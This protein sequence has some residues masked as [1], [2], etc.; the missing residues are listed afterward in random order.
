MKAL[1]SHSTIVIRP[2]NGNDAP[3]YCALRRRV[4][5]LGDGRYFSDSFIRENQLQSE[6]AWRDWC[7][8]KAD[9]CIFGTFLDGA[10]IGVMMITRYDGYGERTVEWE[11]IWLDPVYRRQ[12]LARLAY[13]HVHQWTR[14][15]GYD[16]VALFIRADNL[17]SLN[18][19]QKLGARYIS[20]KHNEIWADGS[21]ADVHTFILDLRKP[22]SLQQARTSHHAARAPTL[23]QQDVAKITCPLPLSIELGAA[24]GVWR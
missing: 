7:T 8:E 6:R 15:H 24:K 11:A 10:L 19:H 14:E 3:A 9:H 17:R 4:L 12:G 1:P 22:F 20:T 18:I 2:L 5:D 21:I 23:L 13:A 16:R